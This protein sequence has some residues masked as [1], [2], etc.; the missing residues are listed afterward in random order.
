MGCIADACGNTCEADLPD[1]TSSDGIEVVVGVVEESDVDLRT[2][3]VDGY[4]VVGEIA[5][6]GRSAA[7][8]TKLNFSLPSTMIICP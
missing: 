6:D 1:S 2:V 7:L 5:V 8:V 4:D 3:C